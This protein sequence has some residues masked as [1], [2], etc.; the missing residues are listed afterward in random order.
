MDLRMHLGVIWRW[1]FLVGFGLLA[2]V[3]LAFFSVCRVD[4]ANGASVSYRQGETWQ[5]SETVLVN[6]PG[7]LYVTAQLQPTSNP[8]WLASLTSLYAQIANSATIRSRVLP[9]GI[10]TKAT[11]D[12]TASQVM[13]Q[14]NQP[15]AVLMFDGTGTSPKQ[16]VSNAHRASSEFRAYVDSQAVGS[17]VR[18]DRR[19]VVNVLS[20]A[21]VHTAK[22]V[23][24]RKLTV[25]ILVFLAVLLVTLGLVYVLENLKGRPAATASRRRAPARQPVRRRPTAPVDRLPDPVETTSRT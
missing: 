13:D 24:G 22:V 14:S 4:L 9:G 5:A 25:P 16:A 20:P 6:Q 10:A 19:V 3:A 8:G 11:G 18:G 21:S 1:R 23:Q 17:K 12:Y 15:L 2:A 7:G